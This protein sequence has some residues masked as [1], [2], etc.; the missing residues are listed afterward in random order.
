MPLSNYQSA[1]S[2]WFATL[3]DAER[4][5]LHASAGEP[6]LTRPDLLVVGGGIIGLSI[7]YFAAERGLRVQLIEA[8]QL[9]G[10]ASG[11]NAGGIWPNDQGPA[12]TTGFQQL[13][14]LS[15]DW[16]ARLAVRPSFHFDW[17]VNGL[18]NINLEKMPAAPAVHAAALQEQGY[19]VQSVDTEQIAS[20][21]PNIRTLATG[22]IHCPSDAHLNPVK[23]ALSFAA[24]ARQRG[25]CISTGVRALSAEMRGGRVISVSTTGGLIESGAVVCASGWTA[26][27]VA[28]LLENPAPLRPVSGQLI[29]TDPQPPL[30][31]GSIAAK[32]II[33][34]LRTGEIV[35][36]GNLLEA[37]SLTPDAAL[38]QQFADA[39]RDLLP[40]LKEVPFTRS[41]C[42]LRPSTPDGSPVI[43]IAPGA[44][45]LWLACGHFR[46]GVL[47]APATGKLVIEWIASNRRPEELAPF[48]L[49]R[50]APATPAN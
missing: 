20:L 35:T 21:E 17:R 22:G 16:W 43:D 7:A 33:L 36:G 45:N 49:D 37:D 1:D 24:A 41:W 38:S 6:L 9:A 26:D 4:L 25:A 40:A 5:Q 47:L 29:A 32:F 11:A 3:T 23:A 10:G 8:G 31:K 13:A 50:F 19:T 2:I 14:F 34:Q 42:G 46:N 44:A 48:R 30:L 15:R 12:H 39:A 18:L 27:W 28:P